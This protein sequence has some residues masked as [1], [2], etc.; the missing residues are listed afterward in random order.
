M[1]YAAKIKA[2][3]PFQVLDVIGKVAYQAGRELEPSD[4]ER[5]LAEMLEA[6][7]AEARDAARVKGLQA[8]ARGAKRRASSIRIAEST[9]PA[10]WRSRLLFKLSRGERVLDAVAANAITILRRDP[11]W[12]GVIAFDSFAQDIV[13][14]R[15][16]PWGEDEAAGEVKAGSWSDA[17]TTRAQA[18]IRRAYGVNISIEA[19]T[20]A[21]VVVAE[22]NAFNPL[23]NWL[24]GLV[25]DGKPRIDR[26]LS[27]YMGARED[28]YTGAVGR[29]FLVS[30]V[31]RAYDAGCKVDTVP[32]FEGAQG[33]QKGTALKNLFSPWYSDTPIDLTNKDRFLVVRGIW[34]YEVAEFDGYSRHDATILK[35]FISSAVDN[36]RSPYGKKSALVPRKV[37]F[38]ATVNP[39]P[40]YL[41]DE[42]G[43]RRY[44]PVRVGELR[45]IDAERLKLERELLWAEAREVYRC[46]VEH[47]KT[48]PATSSPGKWWPGTEEEKALCADEQEARQVRDAWDGPVAVWLSKK[49]PGVTVTVGD[50]LGELLGLEKSKWDQNAQKRAARSL[51]VAGWIRYQER[52]EGVRVWVYG[53]KNAQKTGSG[54]TMS[55]GSEGRV[56][57]ENVQ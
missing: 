12:A 37:V 32:I 44:W 34:G 10:D 25:W 23:A 51:R 39:G 52:V 47:C 18:W 4:H 53:R 38:A 55:P 54:V 6:V 20:A 7:P 5:A 2:A 24:D 30:A 40:D 45:P 19:L 41:Q 9:D 57:T 42:T 29:W 15:S 56:V 11:R 33:A 22:A 35:A 13:T 1:S 8:L 17:D 43:G 3:S 49:L 21:V 46:H 50:V 48:K 27:E 31:A 26:W 14:T 36:Y 16:P 28:A